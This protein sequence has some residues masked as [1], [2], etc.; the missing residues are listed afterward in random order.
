MGKEI[1]KIMYT[2][3]D[4]VGCNKCIDACP[5]ITANLVVHQ[6]EGK[7]SIQVNSQTCIACGACLDV[8]EH[9]ARGYN[10]DTERFFNDLAKGEK[11]SL[12]V[13]PAFR[14]NYPKEY[15]SILGA[16]KKLGCNH[17]M[18]VGF[19][20]D[21]A[22]WGYV[23]YIEKYQVEGMISQPCPAVVSYIEKYI[24]ELIPKLM[25]IHS[26]MICAAI[27]TKKYLG[28]NDK[29]AFIGPC[30][31][32]KVEIDDPNTE[33]YV[34]YNVTFNH[35]LDYLKAH[36]IQ[37][38]DVQEETPCGLGTIYPMPGGLKE[39]IHWFCGEEQFVRQVEGEAKVYAYLEDYLKRVK[40]KDELPFIVDALNCEQGCLYGTGIEKEKN[41]SDNINYEIHKLKLSKLKGKKSS[42]WDMRKKPKER[43]KALNKQFKKL[44]LNDFIRHYKDQSSGC[45]IKI[46]NA[47][48]LDAIFNEMQKRTPEERNINCGACGYGNC[49][50]MATAIYNQC[51][52]NKNCIYFLKSKV[53]EE[54]HIVQAYLSEIEEKNKQMEQRN[55]VMQKVIRESYSNLEVLDFSIKELANENMTNAQR[56]AKIRNTMQD[57]NAF[58]K[59]IKISFDSI[60]AVLEQ[61]EEN[62]NAIAHVSGQTNLLSLNASIEA[63]K[64]GMAGKGFAVV[65]EKIKDLSDASKEAAIKS[66]ENKKEMFQALNELSKRANRLAEDVEEINERV[67]SLTESIEEI[68]G[69]SE[70]VKDS[71]EKLKDS[72]KL[73]NE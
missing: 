47:E 3:Q 62:N 55:Q 43:L 29:L 42:P 2:T 26:P 50:R 71:S 44:E 32:K 38:E 27:Y 48:E 28:N 35:L 70:Q 66:N 59:E 54:K 63:A 45:M 19:G 65:A 6:E 64:A 20:A 17:I 56:G 33:G 4:C 41:E 24:P 18:S 58:V 60:K 61:L 39:N 14:S 52:E 31:A 30:M 15:A 67:G 57:I 68:A 11:I 8:C 22:T 25:P 16:L 21:I 10:D 51:N 40:N 1:K 72:L 12:L 23:N 7:Q 13:A 49:Q 69:A 46:P 53:E 73:L 37:G 36:P 34:S 5:V 9:D